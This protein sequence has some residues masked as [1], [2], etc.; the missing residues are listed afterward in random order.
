MSRTKPQAAQRF[1]GWRLG[2][3]AARDPLWRRKAMRFCAAWDNSARSRRFSCNSWHGAVRPQH[4]APFFLPP[5]RPA[6][7]T[8]TASATSISTF[9][10]ADRPTACRHPQ[11][12]ALA[13]C[14]HRARRRPP[15]FRAA[16]CCGRATC[17]SSTTPKVLHARLFGEKTTGGKSGN[18]WLSGC[19]KAMTSRCTCA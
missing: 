12:F 3:G 1:L 4:H 8:A 6:S 9:H 15:V 7:Q 19:C 10:R 14:H 13:G 16:P 11:R 5:A 18:Y 2:R 17:W